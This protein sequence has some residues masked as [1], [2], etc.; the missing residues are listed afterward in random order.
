MLKKNKIKANNCAY[1]SVN[2][3]HYEGGKMKERKSRTF[4]MGDLHGAYPAL[5]QCLN[6][7]GFDY[8]KD[9]LIQVGDV[10]D[11]HNEVYECVEELLKIKNLIP[12][13]G[14][15]DAW[16]H[17]FIQTDFHPVAWAY[18]GKGTIESYL[19]YKKEGPKVCFPKG[20]GY[21]T[22]L[23]STDIPAHHRQFFQNQK[24]FHILETD[25]CFVHGG[26][27]RYVDFFMQTEKN[28][29]WD[30]QLWTEALSNK[31]EGNPADN[32]EM[33]TQFKSIYVGHTSTLHWGTDQPMSALNITN[34]DTGAGSN[35][36]LTIMDIDT[37]EIWQSDRLDTFYENYHNVSHT[38]H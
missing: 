28:Y 7:S 3:Y 13:K 34:I 9:T 14:N 21:K 17:E 19:K 26:F 6:R 8:Q 37:K 29:C 30:R 20:S 31:N 4:I 23:N 16:F 1:D 2:L 38:Q 32:F 11:G 5:I 27:D 36:K 24:L 35:G 10:A 15:H 33:V 12:I 25:I 22:S 18:G